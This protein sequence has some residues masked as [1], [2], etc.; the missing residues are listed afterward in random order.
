MARRSLLLVDSDARSTRV[1]EVSLKDIKPRIW[2]RFMIRA[3][4]D[5]VDLHEAIQDA[6]GWR[7]CHL[8]Q[9]QDQKGKTLAELP[10]DEGDETGPDAMSTPIGPAL[11][12]KKGKKLVYIYDFGDWW[13]HDLEVI[14]VIKNSPE[15][16]GRK[17][18]A[19]E[20][21]F[22]PEDC[23]G[24]GGYEECVRVATGKIQERERLRW[25][26]GWTP[27]KFDFRETER[28]FYQAELFLRAHYYEEM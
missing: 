11:G 19:G 9:F 13:E 1:L 25:L 2:R 21:A 3:D 24:T 23:G 27:E 14:D 8:F 26:D 17:L 4:A 15:E 16:F 22:P 6:C 5:F 18:L 20:R 7:N 28:L 10:G 12:A